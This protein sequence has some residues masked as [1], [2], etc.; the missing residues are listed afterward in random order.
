MGLKENIYQAFTKS[1]GEFELKKDYGKL[2]KG[3]KVMIEAD[4]GNTPNHTRVKTSEG[5]VLLMPDSNIKPNPAI[6]QLSDDLSKA[7]SKFILDQDFQINNLESHVEIPSITS[8][9][10]TTVVSPTGTLPGTGAGTA[11]SPLTNVVGEVKRDGGGLAKL[12]ATNSLVKLN[13]VK[14]GSL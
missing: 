8:Q 1:G 7:I 5:G 9:V 14:E 3:D 12:A 13:Q 6:D 10:A 11:T 2:R 4:R